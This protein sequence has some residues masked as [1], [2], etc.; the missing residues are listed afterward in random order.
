MHTTIHT[1]YISVICNFPSVIPLWSAVN[2][3]VQTHTTIYTDY[4]SVIC[5]FPSVIPLWSA[6]NTHESGKFAAS[7]NYIDKL[8]AGFLCHYLKF[9]IIKLPHL[10]SAG[11]QQD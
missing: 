2:T 1:D 9:V 10:G 7:Q 5:H 3:H 4:V 11:F 8:Q 6:V